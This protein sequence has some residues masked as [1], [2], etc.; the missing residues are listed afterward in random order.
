M[1]AAQQITGLIL[2]G[3]AGRR[4]AG[5]DKG[6]LVWHGRPLVEHVA[7]RLRPQVST[8]VISCNRN[9]SS[10]QPYADQTVQDELKDYQGPLAG[11]LAAGSILNNPLLALTPCDTPLLPRNM[12]SELLQTMLSHDADICYAQDEEHKHYLCALI[13][14]EAL[15]DLQPF[16][17]AGGRAVKQWYASKHTVAHTFSSAG[18]AFANFNNLQA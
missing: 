18:D 3:G 6:L 4:V 9:L 17:E 1:D 16:V 10:Y 13:R 14:Q 11:L 2:A 7:E 5:Q 15:T 12:V 8:L